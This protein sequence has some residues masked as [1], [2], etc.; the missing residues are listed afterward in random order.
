M[1]K[2][3]LALAAVLLTALA[4]AHFYRTFDPHINVYT[5]PYKKKMA[6]TITCDDISSGYPLEYF[7]EIVAALENHGIRATFFVIPYHGEWDLLTESPEFVEALHTAESK[8]H[9][10][11]LHGYAHYEDEFVCSPEEQSQ[12]LEKALAI[13]DEAGFVVEGFRAP[14]L[15]ATPETQNILK[16]YDFVYD[17][18]A[19][20]DSGEILLE[21]DLPQIPSGHEYTW[22]IAEEELPEKLALAHQEFETKY[23][24]GSIFS[25]VTHMKAVNEGEGMN[26]LEDFLSYAAEK[27]VWNFTLL[28][29]A[30]WELS[31]QNVT[32]DSR[33]T[34]T[35]GEITFQNVLQG[36]GVEIELP[37]H[38]SLKNPPEGV[39][40][41]TDIRDQT[42]IFEVTF[43]QDFEEITVSFGL[44]YGS[45]DSN[46]D[47]E[48]LI[49]CSATDSISHPHECDSGADLDSLETLLA[50]WEVPH[51]VIETNSQISE[52]LLRSSSL[53]LIDDR[54][55]KR[56]L[57]LREIILLYSL[58]N[59]VIVFSGNKN[60]FFPWVFVERPEA[61]DY[62]ELPLKA[63]CSEHEIKTPHYYEIKILQSKSTYIYFEPLVDCPPAHYNNLL[64][65]SLFCAA[66]I[67][68]RKPFFSLEIDDCAMYDALSTQGNTVVADLQAYKNSFDL[69]SSYQ[70]TPL[71]GFTTSYIPYNPEIEEIFSFLKE[72]NA[73]VGNHGYRHSLNFSDPEELAREIS[74]ANTDIE[75]MWGEPPHVIVVPANEMCQKSMVYALEGTPI[76]AVGSSDR[77]YE[78]G[79]IEGILFY[80]RTS[81][82]L[83]SKAVDDTPP[84]SGLFLYSKP[85]LPSVYAVTHI[86]NYIEKETAYQY[87]DDALQF[88]IHTGYTPSD[89]ETM[90]EEDFFWSFVDLKSSVR[91][92]VLVIELSGL[93]SLPKKAYTVHFA[94]YGDPPFRVAAGLYS[95]ESQARYEDNITHV[96]LILQP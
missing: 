42:R 91:G 76:T 63:V 13:M 87:I 56:S 46:M 2:K 75:R 25:L 27:D 8:G 54:F 67:P 29:L 62:V 26:F 85:F 24:E 52:E 89:T 30:E 17:S 28:E 50:A 32:W 74:Q 9:E 51:Q 15:R 14:C 44:T 19:F 23:N 88:L 90:A 18:S 1:K 53:I 73:L 93:E 5:W 35:G 72:N 84:F 60:K 48:L 66:P 34:F 58:E 12:L 45:P 40:V 61:L 41:S 95:V 10:I 71:Y 86:F 82:Q 37:L 69:A 4:A 11:A 78:F 79:V 20:G 92:D 55:L 33:K 36:L 81:L 64:V 49:L 38:Y 94:L 68:V 57:T 77:G 70:L 80:Q 65:R 47:N 83:C 43:H 7:E 59:R 96:T 22:Y 3:A 31:R 21:G 16:E 6:F 39:E